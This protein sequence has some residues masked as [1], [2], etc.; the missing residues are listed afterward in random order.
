MPRKPLA[1]PFTAYAWLAEAGW[2]FMAHS[3][4]LWADPAKASARLAVLA[5]EKQRAAAA[6]MIGASLAVMRGAGPDT[7]AK[8]AMVPVRRRVRLNASKLRNG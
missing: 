8:A 6:G 2:V 7:I 1:N 3:A 5:A 4:Q